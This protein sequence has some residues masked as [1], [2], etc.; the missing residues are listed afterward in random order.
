[1]KA[2]GVGI[3]PIF[4]QK[5]PKVE[6]IPQEDNNGCLS[7]LKTAFYVILRG[8]IY[9]LIGFLFKL[10]RVLLRLLERLE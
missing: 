8:F 2:I 7:L 4:T 1:M 3:S 6:E 10:I 9:K 5:L